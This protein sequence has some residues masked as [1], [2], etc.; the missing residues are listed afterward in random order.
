MVAVGLIGA[1]LSAAATAPVVFVGYAVTIKSGLLVAETL[2]GL[3]VGQPVTMKSGV[4]VAATLGL[5]DFD[6]IKVNS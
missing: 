1:L 3:G 5:T 6:G 4:V 2:T